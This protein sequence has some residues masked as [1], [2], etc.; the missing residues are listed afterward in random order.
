MASRAFQ[1]SVVRD[2]P[3]IH[4]CCPAQAGQPYTLI[5]EKE[6]YGDVLIQGIWE[7]GTDC[8]LDVRVTDTAPTYQMKDPSKVLEAAECLKK[9]KYLQPCLDQRRHFTKCIVSLDGLIGKEA[10]MVLKVL[11]VRTQ[12]MKDVLE[13]HGIYEGT[14]EHSNSQSI[15]IARAT[16]VCRRGSRVPVSRMSKIRP[17]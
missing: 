6:D 8:I 7:R 12:S 2:E 5:T 14:P 17:Q 3:K 13:R 9:K 16:H 15:S 10:K 11:A 4:K 1:S